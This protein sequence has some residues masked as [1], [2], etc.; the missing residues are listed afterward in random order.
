MTMFM[1]AGLLALP[2]GFLVFFFVLVLNLTAYIRIRPLG[3]FPP[4]A[5]ILV[6]GV[7]AV[8]LLAVIG[9]IVLLLPH[10]REEAFG[11]A[12]I[13]FI[14]IAM[15]VVMF[16]AFGCAVLVRKLPRI[17]DS[18]RMF[19]PRPARFSVRRTLISLGYLIIA[20]GIIAAP[21]ISY[22]VIDEGL[23]QFFGLLAVLLFSFGLVGLALINAGKRFH[24]VTIEDLTKSDPRSLVLYL[25]PFAADRALFAHVVHDKYDER[26]T[27]EHYLCHAFQE[28]IGPFVALGSPEDY[29]PPFGD[30]AVRTYATDESWY[31]YFERLAGRAGCIIMLVAHSENLQQELTFIRREGLQRRLFI[32]TRKDTLDPTRGRLFR[33]MSRLYGPPPAGFG[34]GQATWEPFVRT[35]RSWALSSAMTLDAVRWSPSTRRARPWSWRKEPRKR[36]ISWSPFATISCKPLA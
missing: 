18:T 29:L 4:T 24:Q 26:F 10:I 28:R 17:R 21:I 35:S 36:R 2:F 1:V 15:F 16:V 8:T 13:F 12:L 23:G 11:E 19:G 6:L 27:F 30:A 32:F 25:R 34:G 20:G 33:I 14:G 5:A 3:Y 7:D 22:Q 31:E 9:V